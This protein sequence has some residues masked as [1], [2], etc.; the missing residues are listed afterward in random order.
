VSVGRQEPAAEPEPAAVPEPG[1]VPEPAAVPEPGAVP[2]PAAV[3]VHPSPG[4]VPGGGTGSAVRSFHAQLPGYA[5][6][7]L[8]ELAEL[9]GELGVGRLWVKAETDRFGLPSF[10]ILGASWAVQRAVAERCGLGQDAGLG[11]LSAALPGTALRTLLAATDGNHGRAVARVAK[12][13]GLGARIFVPVGTAE[14]RIRAIEGEGAS[15][16]VVDGD[17]DEAVARAAAEE[18]GTSAV[19]SDTSWPG[20]ERI[21]SWVSEGYETILAES[22][23]QL[24]AR[25]A[26]EPTVVVVPTGVG[27]L[28]AAVLRHYRGEARGQGPAARI[29]T[30]EPERAACVLESLR[31]GEPVRV[32]GPHPSI[33]AGLNCGT[34]SRVAWP[35][36]RAGVSVA[37]SIADDAACWAMRRLARAGIEVGETGAAAL[38]GLAALV[39]SGDEVAKR[40]AGL[41]PSANVLV[42]ATEGPTDPARYEEIV[43]RPPSV[44]ARRPD[45][46]V[47]ARRPDDPVGARRPD[48]PAGPARAGGSTGSGSSTGSGG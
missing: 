21:P 29:V 14:A 4:T 36:L 47:G 46:P 22:D 34:P 44:G 48:D 30:V 6:A 9:A 23:A 26:P 28:A 38:G 42:L 1:A 39:A 31:A 10:K 24:E 13:L 41:G 37:V 12:L 15:V 35:L 7:P 2:E 45:D 27:A 40:R 25:G 17:Y 20:Y 16:V 18:D 3:W 5:P 11:A 8:V 33:M 19:V 43:G 32:P